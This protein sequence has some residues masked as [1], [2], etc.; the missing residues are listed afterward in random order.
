MTPRDVEAMDA[1]VRKAVG[2]AARFALDS[3][4]PNPESALEHVFA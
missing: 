4:A 1:D 2:E 3:P